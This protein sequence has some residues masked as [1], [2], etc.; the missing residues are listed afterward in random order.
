MADAA[1]VARIGRDFTYHRPP[2]ETQ[3]TFKALRGKAKELA[4]LIAEHVPPGREQAT[5]LT[6][7]E[8]AVMH[9]NAGIARP[10]AVEEG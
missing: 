6:R 5:A 4:L 7:L 9:A 1:L 8:E 3:A 10:F 2:V